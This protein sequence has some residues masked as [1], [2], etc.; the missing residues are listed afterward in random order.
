MINAQMEALKLSTNHTVKQIFKEIK[1]P[2]NSK[3][4]GRRLA[5]H[6]AS[7]GCWRSWVQIPSFPYFEK[8]NH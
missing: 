3:L 4:W 8:V 1:S 6:T 7:L 2:C 5:W